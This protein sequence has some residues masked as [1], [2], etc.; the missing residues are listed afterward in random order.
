MDSP[1][2][3]P[4]VS[5]ILNHLLALLPALEQQRLLAAGTPV[6][7]R[8]GQVLHQPGEPSPQVYFPEQGSVRLLMQSPG[9]PGLEVGL[10]GAEGMLG[11][12]WVLGVADSPWQAQVQSR[13]TAWQVPQE[14]FQ[15]V[16]GRSLVLRQVLNR[17]LA[18]RLMQLSTAVTCMRYHH[19]GPRLARWLLMSHDRAGADHFEV[20]HEDLATALGVRRVGI[21]E[22]AGRLQQAGWIYYHRGYVK[23]IHRAGLEATACPCYAADQAGYA[24][25]LCAA[26]PIP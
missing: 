11:L 17:Y 25:H 1:K 9:Q 2:A 24:A 10:V 5:S 4:V 21:T 19:I 3:G 14:P 18:V 12:H 16:L 13:G 20:T 26:A 7:L 8:P 15:R 6:S 22:A 23:V